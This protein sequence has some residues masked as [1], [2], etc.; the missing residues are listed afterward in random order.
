MNGIDITTIEALI[1]LGLLLLG[2]GLAALFL[3][4]RGEAIA[5]HLEALRTAQS[6]LAASQAQLAD[7]Q[8]QRQAELAGR[9]SQFADDTAQ[10]N[11]AFR[12][13]LS[14]RLDAVSQRVGASLA[15]TQE[16]NSQNL[17]HLHERLAL[18][19]RAQK[20]IEQLS[21][22]VSGLAGI[23][24]DKQARGAFGEKQ[25][26][27][28]IES[29]LP[30]S[31][32]SYQCKLSN[33]SL[34]DA[35]IHLPNEQGDVAVDSKFPLEAWRR[36]VEADNTHTEDQSRRAFARDVSKHIT[37]IAAKYLI[38]GETHEVALMFL[39]S[40][41]IYAE[42]HAAF[43][44]V[45]ERGFKAKVMIV[46]PTTFMATLHTMKA[47]M[48]DAAMREQAH[49]ILRETAK[50]GEDVRRLDDRVAK[51]QRHFD[52]AGEDVRQIRISTEK[53][54]RRSERME[55]LEDQ[56]VPDALPENV[57]ALRP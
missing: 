23:L 10:R 21:G 48:R 49:V 30:P 25:M 5:P 17:K 34:V 38:F 13:T 8:T 16:R 47:V 50:M 53:I 19:D 22:E 41:A 4:D 9:L 33:G 6:D 51:L 36:M 26:R 2:M 46:S 14:D 43:P 20:N 44:E 3:R 45:I 11:E 7:L 35:L 54:T 24:S 37:D 28:I 15:E 57:T 42:L 55:E 31:S 56:A 1:G 39:P 52:Q 32:F 29:Y 27:D 12:K 40:E 18:I